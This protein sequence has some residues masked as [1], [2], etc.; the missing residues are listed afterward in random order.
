[1]VYIVEDQVKFDSAQIGAING[2]ANQ[3]RYDGGWAV[4]LAR[5]L[6]PGEYKDDLL[7]ASHSSDAESNNQLNGEI[8]VEVYPN[9]SSGLLNINMKNA[10]SSTIC[11]IYKFDGTLV[12]SWVTDK[13]S[14]SIDI[15]N[16]NDGVYLLSVSGKG[17]KSSTSTF[18]LK[19]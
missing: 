12:K 15:S 5:Q 1:M 10:G 13:T 16:L 11:Q 2:I 3:C 14:Q 18:I 9:P 6:I 7:C 4:V 19:H 17:L 8:L